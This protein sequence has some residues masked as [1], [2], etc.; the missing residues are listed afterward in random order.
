MSSASGPDI[1]VVVLMEYRT[2]LHLLWGW[3][4]FLFGRLALRRFAGLRFAKVMGSGHEGGFGLRPSFTRHG[5]F[6]VFAGH[7]SADAFLQSEWLRRA[8]PHVKSW[9]WLKL[10]AF[11]S[12][13]RWSG[14]EIRASAAAP[15]DEP[16]VSLTRASIRWSQTLRFWR[17]APPAEA[18]LAHAGGCTLSVGLGEAP[19]FRQATLS[20]WDSVTSMNAYARSGAHQQAIRA[21]Y[22]GRHFSESMFVRW[23][24]LAQGDRHAG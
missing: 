1:A 20:V 14:H 15:V 2:G 23:R 10:E 11:S 21:A 24:L 6:C 13:G 9:R 19:V 4:R 17:M 22:D 18:A 12:R 3:G 8:Q 7:E 16:V 5:L